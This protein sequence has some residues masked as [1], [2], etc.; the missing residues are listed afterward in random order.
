M[1]L[2]FRLCGLWVMLLV[3][4]LAAVILSSVMGLCFLC[5]LSWMSMPSFLCW[6]ML[7]GHYQISA[8]ASHSHLL[9]RLA[10]EWFLLWFLLVLVA[11]Y[12]CS[13]I[14]LIDKACT[15]STWASYSFKW[16]GSPDWFLLGSLISNW[17]YEWQNPSC[18]WCWCLPAPCGASSVS[19]FFQFI[20]WYGLT[21]SFFGNLYFL[22]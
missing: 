2:N 19:Y 18:Y 22:F 12:S 9:N 14:I 17:W 10:C 21:H 8:E 15:S 16:W 20:L 7:L 5:W 13:L 6:E 1:L 3:I 4:L 11:M